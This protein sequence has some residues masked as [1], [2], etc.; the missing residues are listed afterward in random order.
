MG[1]CLLLALPVWFGGVVT[2]RA[3]FAETT[4]GIVN[5]LLTEERPRILGTDQRLEE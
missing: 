3:P 1:D 4:A 5:D 2:V